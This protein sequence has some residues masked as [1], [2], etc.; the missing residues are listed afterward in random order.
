MKNLLLLLSL[1]AILASCSDNSEHSDSTAQETE[2]TDAASAE[3]I[4]VLE[5][6]KEIEVKA[7]AASSK[8]DSI[9]KSL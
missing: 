7:E 2:T 4:R 1:A 6:T 9:L 5:E 8:A 3:D